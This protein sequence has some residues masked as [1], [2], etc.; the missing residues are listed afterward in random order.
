MT[1]SILYTEEDKILIKCNINDDNYLFIM[2]CKINDIE[3]ENYQK[4]LNHI[5][6]LE[7]TYF[8]NKNGILGRLSYSFNI[9]NMIG[10]LCKFY[11]NLLND[12]EIIFIFRIIEYKKN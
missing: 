10:C 6:F 8:E 11:T 5:K 7:E 12:T 1:K 4:Q 3:I 9:D 2:E